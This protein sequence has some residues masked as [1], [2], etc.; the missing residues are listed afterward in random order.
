MFDKKYKTV[1]VEREKKIYCG[2]NWLEVEIFPAFHTV[3]MRNRRRR[4][5]ET[6][7]A[8]RN[9]NDK[10]GRK[11][12]IRLCL[13]NF[14]LGDFRLEFTYNRFFCPATAAEL[15]RN[16]RNVIR[17]IQNKRKKQGLPPLK[18]VLINA[19]GVSK[20][21]GKMVRPHHHLI[22]NGGLS[23]NDMLDVWRERKKNGRAYG[24]VTYAPLQPD[25]ETGIVG[26]ANYLAEQ[27]GEPGARRWSSS[28]NL[29]KPEF[30][31]NDSRF[32]K[33]QI[34]NLIRAE[35][36]KIYGNDCRKMINF[37]TWCKK[38]PG[39]TLVEYAPVFDDV[40]GAWRLAMRFR[41]DTEPSPGKFGAAEIDRRRR[42]S[43]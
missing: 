30:V 35:S 41:R 25:F 19:F 10:N 14:G 42:C 26:L 34:E 5:L 16:G 1:L 43:A 11:Y 24:F 15:K 31:T 23:M 7:P 6:C 29:Q 39:Y 37:E 13:A 40:L 12:F 27:P 4:I 32:R 38:Y 8:Q 36:C 17:R 21:T 22:V 20:K 2:E 9:L 18:F 3:G 33:R 28:L